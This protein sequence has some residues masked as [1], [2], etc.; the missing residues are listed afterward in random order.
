MTDSNKEKLAIN[1]RGNKSIEAVQAT[2]S[3]QPSDPLHSTTLV[4]RRKRRHFV[5]FIALLSLGAIAFII[6]VSRSAIAQPYEGLGIALCAVACGIL[7]VRHA[8]R[9][10]MEQDKLQEEQHNAYQESVSPLQ[11]NP[12]ELKENPM[13]SPPEAGQNIKLRK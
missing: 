12:A 9:A 11:S 4:A 2:K 5:E 8:F 6:F 13:V 1:T 10:L 3:D 7:L